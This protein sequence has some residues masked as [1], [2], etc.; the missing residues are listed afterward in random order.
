MY[1]MQA[2]LEQTPFSQL[3]N[4]CQWKQLALLF[5]SDSKYLNCGSKD[6]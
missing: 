2:F 3:V 4:H 5:Y 6:I 1:D